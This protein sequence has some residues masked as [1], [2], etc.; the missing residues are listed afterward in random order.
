MLNNATLIL[1]IQRFLV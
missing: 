1:R